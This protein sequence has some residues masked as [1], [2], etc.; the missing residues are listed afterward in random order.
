MSASEATEGVAGYYA[1]KLAEHGPT[2]AGVDWNSAHS[3]ELRFAQLMRIAEGEK[4][5]SLNDYGCGYGAL[6]D[7][8]DGAGAQVEYSGFDL[9]PEMVEAARERF[10]GRQA[11]FTTDAAELQVA[12]YTVASGIFNVR[13]D[14]D[15][16][17][18]LGHVLRTL[19]HLGSLSTRGFAFNVLTSYSDPDRMRPDLFYADPGVI[20]DHCIRRFSRRVAILHDYELYE[21]TTLVRLTAETEASR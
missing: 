6:L 9:A 5:F 17:T 4:R 8:L 13:L 14:V 7:H 16:E 1:G 10:A 21:F 11:R 19:E 20:L 3:Q 2:P 18:W 12:D 15:D